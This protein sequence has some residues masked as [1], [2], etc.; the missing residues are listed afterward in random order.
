MSARSM[1]GTHICHGDKDSFWLSDPLVEERGSFGAK[2]LFACI[3]FL[4]VDIL[5][6]K[7]QLFG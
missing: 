2:V 3:S 1:F 4:S 5:A 7:H 6:V